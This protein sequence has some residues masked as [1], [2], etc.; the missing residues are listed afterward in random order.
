MITQTE[1]QTLLS[2]DPDTGIF[3][4]NA[5]TKHW[6][7]GQAVGSPHKDGYLTVMLKGKN[8][9]LHRLAFLYME[10]E[11]PRACVDHRNRIRS[12]NRWENL[13]SATYTL[14]NQNTGISRNNTSGVKG[15]SWHKKSGKWQAFVS[16]G[17]RPVY[18]GLFSSIEDAAHA[19]A[20]AEEEYRYNEDEL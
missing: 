5:D 6:H 20:K 19:R 18:L 2:Y 12:D 13:R 10:G 7:R 1:L 8:Y 9:L 17:S 15:V 14:N 3:R 11:F 16:C 4:S